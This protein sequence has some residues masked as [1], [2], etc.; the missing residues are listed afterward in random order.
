MH[1]RFRTACAVALALGVVTLPWAISAAPDDQAGPSQGKSRANNVYVI[2][3]S[4]PPVVAFDGGIAGLQA[5]RPA[6]GQKIDPL[7]PEVVR[8][9]SYLDD[10]HQR[11]LNAVSGGRKLY[12]YRYS[13]NGFAAELTDAQAEALAST[14]GV[15]AVWKDE[16][17]Y[18]ETS[19]TP[20]FIGLDAPGGLWDQ[21][22][23][24]GNAGEGIIIGLIDSGVWPEHPSFSDRTGFNGNMTKSG[25]LGYQ[26]IP[27]WHGKCTPG[28]AFNASMC[29]QKLIGAQWFNEAWGGNAGIDAARPWEFNSPRDYQGHGSHT[30]STAGG[31]N[32]VMPTGPAAFWGTISGIAPRARI[33]MYKALWS[34]QDASTASGYNSDLVAAIDQAVS[35]G[36]DVINYSISGTQTNFRDPVEIAFMYAADAGVFVATSAGNSGPTTSTVAHPGPWLTTVAAGTHNRN[37]EGSVTLGNGAKYTGVSTAMTV[38]GPAPFID[39]T[40]AGLPGADPTKVALCYAAADNGGAPVLDPA[41]VAGKIVLCDRG[42]TARVNKSLAVYEAG[43]IGMV[44]VNTSNNT[45]NPDVHSVPTVHL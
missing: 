33:A 17:Q 32:S 29:N 19:T 4:Q 1:H 20:T 34:T 16:M 35:D 23:G 10:Q 36:V 43:G 24:K 14:P 15:V 44:L 6:R 11:A 25:R 7:S 5:T 12:S 2:Q 39:S 13:F 38:A 26:Q 8:Y 30:S 3:M 28:E 37:A 41:K 31:N 22:G 40:T 18:A 27:G 9:V 42:V 21:L 45:L